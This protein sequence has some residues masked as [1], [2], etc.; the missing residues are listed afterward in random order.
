MLIGES[1][2]PAD[3]KEYLMKKVTS[4]ICFFCLIC[5]FQLSSCGISREKMAQGIQES[6]QEKMNTDP[7][8]KKY[9]MKVQKVS[10]VKSG[11]N[12]YDG[13]VNILLDNETHDVSISVT[14]EGSS[15]KW[16]IKPLAFSFLVHYELR[17]FDFE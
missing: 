4:I 17:N 8:Y 16:E 13:Y 15:Y 2:Q 6:F 1:R 5:I 10:L 11:S 7:A 3:D 9:Q 14:T 12:L